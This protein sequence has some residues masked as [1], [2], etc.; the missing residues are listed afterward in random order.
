MGSMGCKRVYDLFQE[1]R[2]K[3]YSLAVNKEKRKRAFVIIKRHTIILQPTLMLLL[4]FFIIMIIT[5]N[6]N[7]E[8]MI[9]LWISVV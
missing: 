9:E 4:E 5:S 7:F 2:Y 1:M 8:Q 3:R 6:K